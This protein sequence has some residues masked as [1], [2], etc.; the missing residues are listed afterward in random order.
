MILRAFNGM[1][2]QWLPG[3]EWRA[4]EP[5]GGL[6]V[7]SLPDG[8]VAV[9]NARHPDSPALIFSADELTAFVEGA[10]DGVFDD[11]ARDLPE[12]DH[13]E[14]PDEALRSA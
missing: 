12:R 7:A 4:A 9:R 3:V 1:P 13:S 2:A 6:E 10:R 11:I 5:G 8:E 14:G